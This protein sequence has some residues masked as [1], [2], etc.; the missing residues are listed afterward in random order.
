MGYFLS[1]TIKTTGECQQAIDDLTNAPCSIIKQLEATEKHLTGS[2]PADQSWKTIILRL[3]TQPKKFKKNH[4]GIL[5]FT[6][7]QK[8]M[9]GL[10][11]MR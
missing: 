5:I 6:M 7:C 1:C 3:A 9:K 4:V 8:D 11:K 2:N 10:T